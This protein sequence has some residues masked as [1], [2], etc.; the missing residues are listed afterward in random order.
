M[1]YN[2]TQTHKD[3]LSFVRQAMKQP[4]LEKEHELALARAWFHNRDERALHELIQSYTRLVIAIAI[5]YR[6]YGIALSDLIQEGTIGLIEAAN[7]FDPER[8]VRFSSYAKWWVRAAMQDFILRNWSI[9]RTGSTTAHKSLFFNLNRLRKL[10]GHVG[11]DAMP[12]SDQQHIA[13]ELNVLLQDVQVMESR[14]IFG[15]VSLSAA[16]GEDSDDTWVDRIRDERLT[17]EEH[18]FES[19]DGKRRHS[20]IVEA[21]SCLNP[22]EQLVIQKRRLDDPGETLEGIGKQIGVTKERVRQVESKALRKMRFFL[23]SK[24]QEVRQ[25]MT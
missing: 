22:R 15:D 18:S 17:P 8:E 10:L 19:F 14:L 5:R 9:V 11:G 4:M 1:D 24:L 6:H 7:R 21:M 20:W 13:D 23:M 12:I 2:N 25:F 3:D 16:I